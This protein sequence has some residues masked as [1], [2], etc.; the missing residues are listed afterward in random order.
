METLV[1]VG[2]PNPNY[3]IFLGEDFSTTV[4]ETQIIR[5]IIYIAQPSISKDIESAG[6]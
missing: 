3:S 4:L 2:K 5:I 1:I 6:N